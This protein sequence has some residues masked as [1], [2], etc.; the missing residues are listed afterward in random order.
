MTGFAMMYFQAPSL[1]TFQSRLQKDCSNNLKTMFNIES[2]PKETQLWDGLDQAP[3]EELEALFSDY[4]FQLQRAKKLEHYQFLN[5]QYLIPID[6][7]QYFFSD[8]ICCPGCYRSSGYETGVTTCT[9]I[10]SKQRWF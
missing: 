3:T 9:G 1:L 6:G 8:K 10:N 7:A 4:L 5:G 2:I